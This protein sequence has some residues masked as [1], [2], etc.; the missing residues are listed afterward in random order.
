MIRNIFKKTKSSKP[1]KPKVRPV[2]DPNYVQL[3]TSQVLRLWIIDKFILGKSGA[4]EYAKLVEKSGKQHSAHNN[5]TPENKEVFY[6][7]IV[8]DG[9]VFEVMR[10]EKNLADILLSNP[11]FVLFD[12]VKDSVKIGMDYKNNEFVMTEKAESREHKH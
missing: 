2:Y 11:E 1:V 9:E 10:A 6:L 8:I 4:E 5:P 7:A 3:T 12:P